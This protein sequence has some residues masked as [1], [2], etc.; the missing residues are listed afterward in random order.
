MA[1]EVSNIITK[2]I[3]SLAGELD[4]ILIGKAPKFFFL[5]DLVTRDL[6]ILARVLFGISLLPLS[7]DISSPVV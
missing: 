2:Y 3:T 5:L 4:G 7:E 6:V 1:E